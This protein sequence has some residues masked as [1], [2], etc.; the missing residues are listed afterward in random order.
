MLHT[1][2]AIQDHEDLKTWAGRD[3]ATMGDLI[4]DMIRRERIRREWAERDS[5]AQIENAAANR[6]AA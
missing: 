6:G 5:M 4:R 1:R 3:D 2:I